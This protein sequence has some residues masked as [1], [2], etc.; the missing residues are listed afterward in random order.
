MRVVV[1]YSLFDLSFIKVFKTDGT[2]I[3]RAERVIPVNPMASHFGTPTDVSDLKNKL[4]E[5]RRAV[6]Q[7]VQ[8]TRALV[9]TGEKPRLEWQDAAKMPESAVRKIETAGA[10]YIG[11]VEQ[12]PDGAFTPTPKF[13]MDGP[14]GDKA[15]GIFIDP[16][17]DETGVER[18][19]PKSRPH[20]NTQTERFEWHQKYGMATREDVTWC[21]WFAET[22]E[23]KMLFKF[24]DDQKA[25]Q[26][27]TDAK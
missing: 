10:E 7:T 16:P 27:T 12:I 8:G 26:P 17:A 21:L 1:K 18:L 11:R 25:E 4:S 9:G 23:Y 14:I 5:Q 24:F 19:V 3:C 22:D 15:E 6:K 2:P 13:P 20:F